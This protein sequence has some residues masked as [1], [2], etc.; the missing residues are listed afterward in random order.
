[1]S[2]T[3]AIAHALELSPPLAAEDVVIVLLDLQP[4]IVARSRTNPEPRLRLASAV[5]A[6]AADA[7]SI[8]ILRSLIRLDPEVVP[9]TIEELQSHPAL[10]RSTVGVLDD[11]ESRT[12]LVDHG[13][14]TI[15]IGGVST[16][17]S[18]LHSALGARRSGYSVHVLVDL[19]G[20]HDGRAEQAA[21]RQMEAAGVT[22]SSV[23]SFLTGLAPDLKSPE[24]RAVLS[25]LSRLWAL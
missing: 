7:L 8:P 19:C 20:G 9:T 14:N 12:A 25:L 5:L 22:L 18:V 16:E 23:A 21:F 24:F 17:V 4:Q 15:I 2:S 3:G 11:G 6:Q 1:M 13:R 10:I